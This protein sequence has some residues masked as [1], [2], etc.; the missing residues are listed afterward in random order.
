MLS[1][2]CYGWVNFR[3]NQRNENTLSIMFSNFFMHVP[4]QPVFLG[5]Q[6]KSLLIK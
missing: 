3:L 4:S 5:Q 1:R 2:V 6:I